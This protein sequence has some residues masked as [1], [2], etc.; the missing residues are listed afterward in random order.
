MAQLSYLRQHGCDQIQG[1]YFSPPLPLKELEALLASSMAAGDV[2][3]AQTENIP[4][5]QFA[6]DRFNSVGSAA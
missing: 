6:A 1:Y 4:P 2:A 5:E 3:Q